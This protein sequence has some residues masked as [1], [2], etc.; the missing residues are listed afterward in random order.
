MD[1]VPGAHEPI[2]S[3]V[4]FRTVSGLLRRDTR[5][6]VQKKTVYPFSGLLFC[7]DCKQNMIRK[8]FRQAGKNTFTTPVPPTGRT[9]PPAPPI[10]S[11]RPC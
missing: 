8:T 7:A 9:K 1:Q 6:A 11:V 4:D 3:E 5:I 10:I 2:I